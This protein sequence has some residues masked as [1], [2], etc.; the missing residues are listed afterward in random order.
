MTRMNEDYINLDY[1]LGPI[2][3]ACIN[4]GDHTRIPAAKSNPW[5]DQICPQLMQLGAFERLGHA[6]AALTKG[7]V[8]APPVN[9]APVAKTK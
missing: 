8:L 5:L 7:G 1:N 2:V 3:I 9:P 6:A 4:Y